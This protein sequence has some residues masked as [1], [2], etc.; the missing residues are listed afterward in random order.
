[1]T[2]VVGGPEAC[3]EGSSNWN[4]FSTERRKKNVSNASN[5]PR[6][7]V[8]LFANGEVTTNSGISISEESYCRQ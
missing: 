1:M 3:D 5:D 6:I 7:L 8:I 4:A 2:V